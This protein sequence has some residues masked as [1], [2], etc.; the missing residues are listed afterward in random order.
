MSEPTRVSVTDAP[1]A[2]RY[3]ARIDGRLAGFAQYRIADGLITFTHTEVKE[4][5]EGRGIGGQLARTA[6]DEAR[7]RDLRVDPQCPFIRS[8]IERHAGYADLMG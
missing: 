4:E 7:A 5:F 2:R 3:E 1:D 6:L 8:W